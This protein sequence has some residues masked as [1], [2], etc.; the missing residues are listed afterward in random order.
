MYVALNGTA[1]VYNTD[2]NAVQTTTWTEWV[3]P[4]Q[5]FADMGVPL[6]NVTS[7][8]IGF[9]TRGNTTTVGGTGQMYFDDIRLYRPKVTTP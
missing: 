6:T 4:L 3:I 2:P 9:G 5:Q 8:T 7:I 1:V